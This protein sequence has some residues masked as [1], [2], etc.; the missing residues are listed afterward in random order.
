MAQWPALASPT[1]WL[2]MFHLVWGKGTSRPSGGTQI[3][4][5]RLY[6]ARRGRCCRGNLQQ[7]VRESV[8]TR[9]FAR[10]HFISTWIF[11]ASRSGSRRKR[12]RHQVDRP[13]VFLAKLSNAMSSVKMA[14][15]GRFSKSTGPG[16][17][18]H[19]HARNSPG[20]SPKGR[21]QVWATGEPASHM[22]QDPM[23]AQLLFDIMMC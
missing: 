22:G 7:R 3:S 10:L 20:R 14:L 4:E 1:L 19:S 15:G 18:A 16:R 6:R 13:L 8:V 9:S 23:T 2:F 12:D 17:I 5:T 11:T 21:G